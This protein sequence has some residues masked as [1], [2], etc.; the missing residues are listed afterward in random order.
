P[1]H[2]S[3]FHPDYKYQGAGPTPVETVLHAREIALEAGLW[4]V[5]AGNVSDVEGN[6][7]YCH[8]CG[9]TLV[10]RRGFA[11]TAEQLGED[12]TCRNCGEPSHFVGFVDPTKH[13]RFWF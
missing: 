9:Q 3:A 8:N 4:Y 5:Y 7:S 13:F 2:F 1:L 12:G 6:T 10:S 11:A